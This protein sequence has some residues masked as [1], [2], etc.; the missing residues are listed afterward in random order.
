M[1]K[2]AMFLFSTAESFNSKITLE[3]NDI[4]TLTV[5]LHS[6]GILDI[7]ENLF[8]PTDNKIHGTH[9]LFNYVLIKIPMKLGHA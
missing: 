2:C 3:I 6:P 7:R 4:L 8:D 1:I 5:G 9:S